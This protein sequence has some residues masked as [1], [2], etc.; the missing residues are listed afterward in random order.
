M[1]PA[2]KFNPLQKIL[3][4]LLFFSCVTAR[5]QELAPVMNFDPNEY[6]AGNQNWMISQAGDKNI[7]VA[8][9][10]GLLE[11]T[12]AHWNLYPVPNNTIVRAVK[13]V[14]D[15]IFTG[16]YMEAGFW[17]KDA[18]GNLQYTSLLPL[19]PEKVHDGEQF[20]HIENIRETVVLQSFDDIYLYNLETRSLSVL[21]IP[22]EKPI[23]N[24]Y[25]VGNEIYFFIPEDGLFKITEGTAILEI[26][27]SRL[28]GSEIVLIN[29]L[30]EGLELISRAGNFYSWT[31][32][33]LKEIYTDLSEELAGMSVFSA[34][35]LQDDSFLLGSVEDG[36]YQF[37]REGKL[38]QHYNQ[39]K[40]LQNNT[41]LALYLDEEQNVWA[42]LDNGLSVMNLNSPFRL[43]QDNVGKIGTVY[44]SFQN[45]DYLYLGTNQGLYY[46]ENGEKEFHFIEGTNGQVWSLQE[47]Q[48]LLFCGHNNGTFLVKEE[49]IEKVSGRMGTWIVKNYKP[50]EDVFIQGHYNGFSFLKKE[51][52]A[53]K[54]LP[55][56]N[57]F[58][59]SSKYIVSDDKGQLWIGNEHKGVFRIR[60]NDSLTGITHME[61]YTFHNSIG[62]TSSIFE[63][64]DSLYYA[65]K[66]RIF[67]YRPSENA[68][69]EDNRLNM[70]LKGKELT[71][72]RMI[73][74]DNRIWG[75][76]ENF[77]FDVSASQLN[78]E[79]VLK[80]V[81]IPKELRTIPQGYENIS[82]LNS[83]NYLLGLVDGYL[84]FDENVENNY[85]R[86]E[87]RIESIVGSTLEED[88]LYIPLHEKMGIAY[89]SNNLRISFSI[90]EYNKFLVPVFSY[91]LLG[92][93]DR[94][95]NWGS[96][97]TATFKNLSYGN[98]TFELRGRI[99]DSKPSTASYSFE[100][101]RPWYLSNLAIAVYI[102]LFLGLLYLVHRVYQME[103]DKRIRE[104]EKELRMKNLEA[105][106]EIIKL[107]NEQL[108]REMA[109]K[110][111]ELA[112]STMSLI[113]KNEFLT[114]LKEKLKDSGSSP[115]VKS[116]IKTIDK[117]IS[118]E[119]NW[120]FFKKA[121]NNADKDFFKKIKSLHPELTSNDL[122]LCAY[123]RLNLTSK[124]IAPL[125][126]I[127]VKSVEIKRYRLRK[128]MDLPHEQNLIEHILE[129]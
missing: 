95:S 36:F 77:V 24:M 68:F 62:I 124:E 117:D 110:N 42:G 108:E 66:N 70:L 78:K 81:F 19:F 92:L 129:I 41:V 82:H 127:S 109:G 67:Q 123:L 118:E 49:K 7:Y 119:D 21:D 60:V 47:V 57:D 26:P 29:P 14:D 38:L 58:T 1:G 111:K 73:C 33:G 106:R 94:W 3:F 18:Y 4:F 8:N 52:D 63:F 61:N 103:H 71:S 85:G 107:Q 97:S 88:S 48:G 10:M 15:L 23:S 90:P 89:K 115:Q 32:A 120:K 9:S 55:M 44:T 75:F 96:N 5:A 6:R 98:Y 35:V 64:Q 84:I 83:G 31:A 22:S 122:K 76:A 11:Y 74:Q 91:R 16:A 13:V 54:E 105:E 34:L 101:L 69:S 20:W 45:E 114:D 102:L 79:Y 51:G 59:H 121:F 128:K 125:L 37:D 46:R 104:H 126:N 43:F 72:G 113:R 25:K 27:A 112:A 2:F 116:V 86:G 40:G 80:N 100:I 39:E 53:F 17:K 12:G 50:L 99:G 93:S 28:D 56:V 87:V 65:T 30:A